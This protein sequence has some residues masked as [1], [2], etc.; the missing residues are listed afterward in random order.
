MHINIK[1]T[2]H[3]SIYLECNVNV[4]Q[5]VHMVHNNE[6]LEVHKVNYCGTY[7]A[8]LL[9]TLYLLKTLK[10]RYTLLVKYINMFGTRFAFFI[11][12]I[13]VKKNTVHQWRYIYVY[14]CCTSG[15]RLLFFNCLD[16]F[17]EQAIERI[18]SDSY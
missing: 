1:L 11:W 16:I 10:L 18:L 13:Y 8:L 12:L 15:L 3:N 9:D 7:C 2:M 5:T 14:H 17:A 6:R 4:A